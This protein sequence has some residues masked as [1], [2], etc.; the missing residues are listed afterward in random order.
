MTELHNKRW[1]ELLWECVPEDSS[2]FGRTTQAL[3]HLTL[4][5]LKARVL[6]DQWTGHPDLEVEFKRQI[7]R[8]EAAYISNEKNYYDV[9]EEDLDA[10]VPRNTNE[11]GFIALLDLHF[12][13]EW[14]L[15][16][17]AK[18][19]RGSYHIIHLKAVQDKEISQE[20]NQ[21][22]QNAIEEYGYSAKGGSYDGI[23]DIIKNRFHS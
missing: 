2:E 23:Y 7:W 11:R 4:L 10:I 17:L 16:D 13:P 8:I 6:K 12:I 22:F 9:E 3:L 18:L 5:M 21:A 1:V 15:I 19:H 20:I 14:H